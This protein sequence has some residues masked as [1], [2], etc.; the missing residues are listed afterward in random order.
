LL[1][2]AAVTRKLP[3]IHKKTFYTRFG[4]LLALACLAGTM[5]GILF[6]FG[7]SVLKFQKRPR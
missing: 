5:F 2:E 1:Q 7:K 6:E 3:L 4:D